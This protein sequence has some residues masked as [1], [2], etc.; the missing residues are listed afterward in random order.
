[1]TRQETAE[2]NAKLRETP[3][4]AAML[5]FF[6]QWPSHTALG[7]ALG[8]RQNSISQCLPR[9]RVAKSIARL[10]EEK[11]GY[12]KEKLR[13]DLSPDDWAMGDAG[14]KAGAIPNRD[15]FHQQTLLLLA[16]HYGSVRNFALSADISSSDYHR[17]MSRDTIPMHVLPRLRR[18]ETTP[19][20]AAR[21][22]LMP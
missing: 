5:E 20:I 22:A 9:G 11:L 12:P 10:A 4:G 19:E 16:E 3:C 1:M 21:L 13:P 18:L 15:G 7:K 6:A 8:L 14:K 2:R 17:W